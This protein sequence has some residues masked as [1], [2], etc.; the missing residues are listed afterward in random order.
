M[1]TRS[2]VLLV[3][4]SCF[5]VAG[6]VGAPLAQINKPSAAPAPTQPT[7]S[8]EEAPKVAKPSAAPLPV[9]ASPGPEGSSAQSPSQPPPSQPA[10]P[11]RLG[12]P[13]PVEETTDPIPE[14]IPPESGIAGWYTVNGT[15]DEVVVEH[16]YGDIYSVDCEEGWEAVGILEGDL[17]QGV[18][19][20]RKEAGAGMAGKMGQ[21]VI[22]WIDPRQPKVQITLNGRSV[23]IS[24]RW[25][26]IEESSEPLSSEASTSSEARRPK[27][28]DYVHVEELPET[29]TRVPPQYPPAARTAGIEGVVQ[30][31]ALVVENGSVGDVRVVKGVPGLDDAAMTAVRQWQF[32]PAL[33]KGK[34]VAVWVAVPVRFSIH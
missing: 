34:P 25:T 12:S 24:S 3:S 14:A 6:G 21:L 32:K 17:Y 29:I 13:P 19:R 26:R 1:R 7:S 11:P 30:L 8:S 22:D 15:Q 2:L 20:Y 27:S 10:S 31:R 28:G 4:L 9:S 5:A 23:S 18:F 33:T 16:L